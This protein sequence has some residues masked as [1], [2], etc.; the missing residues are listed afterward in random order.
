M[1]HQMIMK[2]GWISHFGSFSPGWW[3]WS[4]WPKASELVERSLIHWKVH[5]P[6]P[7]VSRPISMSNFL[8]KGGLLHCHLPLPDPTHPTDNVSH[9]AWSWQ[10]HSLSFCTQCWHMAQACRLSGVEIVSFFSLDK[11]RGLVLIKLPPRCGEKLQARYSS[12]LASPGAA[13]LCL[14]AT[15]GPSWLWRPKTFLSFYLQAL[16]LFLLWN[17]LD[18][19]HST[20]SHWCT[21]SFP[22]GLLHQVRS[23]FPSHFASSWIIEI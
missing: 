5:S 13:S 3:C 10:R 6:C 4:A 21:H 23:Y 7:P 17:I 8:F 19:V 1:G 20:C 9:L 2:S 16:L 11:T 18:Q 14:A 12:P 22:C 15:T